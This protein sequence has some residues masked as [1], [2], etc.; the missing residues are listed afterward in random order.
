MLEYTPDDE[1]ENQKHHELV[2]IAHAVLNDADLATRVVSSLCRL[3][4]PKDPP[5]VIEMMTVHS[6]GARGGQS[7]KPGNLLINMKSLVSEFGDIGLAGAAGAVDHRLVP[8]AALSIWNKLWAHTKIELT[9]EQ[10]SLVYAMWLQRDDGNLVSR[11]DALGMCKLVYKNNGLPEPTSQDF[12]ETVSM[13]LEL[14][15]IE[16]HKSGKIWLREWVRNTY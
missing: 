12:D 11:A 5:V 2:E 14:G 15:C 7:R 3:S 1:A 4:P 16:W 9:A 13:L 6:M 8:L 10:A